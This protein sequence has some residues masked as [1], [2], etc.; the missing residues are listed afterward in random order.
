MFLCGLGSMSVISSLNVAVQTSSPPWVRARV[1]S[2]H[3]LVFQGAVA[4][5]SVGWGAL[6]ARTS[7][8]TAMVTAAVTLLLTLGARARF[9]LGAAEHD[10]SPSLHWPKPMLLCEPSLDDGPVL[11]SVDY[12]VPPEKAA[13]FLEAA[14]LLGRSRRRFGAFQWDLFRDPAVPDRFVEVYVV[15][16]WGDHLRQHDRVSV[17]QQ[18]DETRLRAFLVPGFE[19]VV[20]HLIAARAVQE[21]EEEKKEPAGREG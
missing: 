17:E 5:G 14:P 18:A 15:E 13:R 6:A 7:V 3:M 8:R 12:R 10:F 16:S 21:D 19:P 4:F 11:V 20:T 2:V 1:L 9:P